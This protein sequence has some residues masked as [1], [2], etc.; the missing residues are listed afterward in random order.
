MNNLKPRSKK[1]ILLFLTFLA[2]GGVYFLLFKQKSKK[3]IVKHDIPEVKVVNNP[4]EILDI[5]SDG[6]GLKDWEE[7][8]WKLDPK[9]PDS[10][11][12]GVLDGEEVKNKIT[13]IDTDKTSENGT[14]TEK[15]LTGT[16]TDIISKKLFAEYINLK[17]TGNFNEESV[18]AVANNLV[19][20]QIQNKK[21]VQY[22]FSKDIKT[23]PSDDKILLKLYGDSFASIK[24]KYEKQYLD[25][26]L[27]KKGETANLIDP[28]FL[29]GLV[30]ASD[31]YKNMTLELSKIAVPKDL[32]DTHMEILNNYMASSDGL[33]ELSVLSTDP[34]MGM[35]GMQRHT[36]ATIKE[37]DLLVTVAE[38]L[39]G[40]G[41]IFSE[42]EDGYMWNN[43]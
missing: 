10:N 4:A 15:K 9:N 3:E 20:E 18:L 26:P 6:D 11:G 8:L 24:K 30:R 21:A 2:L 1:I 5:D 39:F 12:D 40:K 37:K 16:E 25:N 33:K 29:Q 36:E 41:I 14:E 7:T 43:I 13:E 38:N 22:Y 28:A 34:V 31:I 42:D 19:A 17:Q 32:A 27:V 35:I 23:F